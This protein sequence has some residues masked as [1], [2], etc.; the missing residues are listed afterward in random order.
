VLIQ[1]WD[2]YNG[3]SGSLQGQA[4]PT[5]SP[6]DYRSFIRKHLDYF[7][8]DIGNNVHKKLILVGV[9]P[10]SG[11]SKGVVQCL[12]RPSYLP[13]GCLNRFTFKKQEGYSYM[14]NQTLNDFADDNVQVHFINPYDAFCKNGVCESM[15]LK[16]G[17]IWYSD[18]YHLSQQ[19]S[20]HAASLV[21]EGVMKA[22]GRSL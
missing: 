7:L 6:K 11:D 2:M 14:I 22:L 12:S 13:S 19:G 4:Y 15:N 18:G 10:G 3:R 20:D 8:S 21:M 16:I 9:Q 1:N 5:Y 17:E